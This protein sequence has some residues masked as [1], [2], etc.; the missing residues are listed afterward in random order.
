[1]VV[2]SN[3]LLPLRPEPELDANLPQ[4]SPPKET[5]SFTELQLICISGPRTAKVRREAEAGLTQRPH[6][7]TD[8]PHLSSFTP[9]ISLSHSS[10]STTTHLHLTL[11]TP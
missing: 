11:P 5:S 8:S 2:R 6:F 1:M 3:T 7:T 9:P 4:C 10:A